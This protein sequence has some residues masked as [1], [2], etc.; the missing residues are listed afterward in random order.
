MC[1]LQQRQVSTAPSSGGVRASHLPP[2]HRASLRTCPPWD[3]LPSVACPE[4][5]LGH[6]RGCCKHSAM[7][8]LHEECRHT[9]TKLLRFLLQGLARPWPSSS[10]AWSC[11]IERSS[12]LAMGQGHWSLPPHGSWPCRSIRWPTTSCRASRR[13]MVSAEAAAVRLGHGHGPVGPPCMY[14]LQEPQVTQ[15]SAPYLL[16]A[17]ACQRRFCFL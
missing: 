6:L 13:P 1:W 17:P 15:C 10:P 14:P 5:R 8:L 4:R 16:R 12:C 11:C 3:A 7:C 9:S 2:F